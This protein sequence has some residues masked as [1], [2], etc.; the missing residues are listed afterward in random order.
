MQQQRARPFS[1]IL[2]ELRPHRHRS[3]LMLQLFGHQDYKRLVLQHLTYGRHRFHS[4][5]ERNPQIGI[6][7]YPNFPHPL[8]IIGNR[9]FYYVDKLPSD[10]QGV[11]LNVVGKDL[12]S[13]LIH[14]SVEDPGLLRY[15]N[16]NL[17]P[18][19][20]WGDIKQLSDSSLLAGVYPTYYLDENGKVK[21][22]GVSFYKS[23][24]EGKNWQI[25]GKIPFKLSNKDPL[26]VGKS[27]EEPTFEILSDST[28]LCVMRSGTT[29]PMYKAYSCD[30]GKTWTEPEPF[31]PN[32][33]KP[34]L[35]LLENGVLVLVSGRPGIQ[36]RFC[37]DGIGREW[38]EPIDMISFM[39]E[40]GTF[41]RDVSCGYASVL[42]TGNN[43]FY[44]VYSDFTT[45]NESD[46]PR[47]SIWFRQI[48]VNKKK[49]IQEYFNEYTFTLVHLV[50]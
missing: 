9:S 5:Q 32:G 27:F 17:M 41:I 39:R 20:W 11:Y 36:V 10:L 29:S 25:V 16:D 7:N 26:Q 42:L 12:R 24:N 3:Q 4:Y 30:F 34:K 1:E 49:N 6:N 45:K 2:R 44:I 22:G 31:T 40:D 48:K 21:S 15:A 43:S 28:L 19:V 46:E 13:N 50:G 37:F 8:E 14:A 38:T 18:V 47:K 33:V 23:S 35:M